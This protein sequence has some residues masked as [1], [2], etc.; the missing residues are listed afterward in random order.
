MKGYYFSFDSLL[1]LSVIAGSLF[2]VTQTADRSSSSFE[3]NT[4]GFQQSSIAGRD[5]MELASRQ[6]FKYFNESFQNELVSNTVMEEEDLDRTI[7]DGIGLLWA[8]QN[9]TYAETAAK[10]YFDSR[11]PGNFGYSIRVNESGNGSV[12]YNS[13]YI[14]NRTESVTAI[15]RLVSGHR[16]GRPSEGF[17]A[18]ARLSEY[19]QQETKTVTLGGYVGD[20]NINANVSL[21]NYDRVLN[22]SIEGDISGEFDLEVNGASAGSYNRSKGNITPSFYQVCT[23]EVNSSRC[24]AF[25]EGYNTVSF[26][27]P[28][29]NKSI[30]GAALRIR[31][32]RTKEL[33][34]FEPGNVQQRKNLPGID[35]IINYYG[36][37]HVPGEIDEI[38]S[39]LRY[40]V[41]NQTV[42]LRIA[43]S[44]VYEER[45]DGEKTVSIDNETVHENLTADGLDYEDI[46][47]RTVPLRFGLKNIDRIY[48]RAI[49]DSVAVID[50]SGSMGNDGKLD[51]AKDSAKTFVDIILNA[52]GNRAGVVGYDSS[53]TDTRYLTRDQEALNDTIDGLVADGGTCIACG[54]LEATDQL[55]DPYRVS[56]VENGSDLI[57]NDSLGSE[58]PAKDGY[59]WT[60]L[61]YN[62]SA[63]SEGSAVLGSEIE[64][65]TLIDSSG[66]LFFRKEFFYEP[67]LHSDVQVA[68]RTDDA[69]EVWLN[70][71][72]VF[73]ESSAEPP[74]YWN[75]VSGAL[76][77]DEY[78]LRF[79]DSFER[80]NLGPN[81]TL[82]QGSVG[83]DLELSD[84]CGS[85][86]GSKSMVLTGG[87]PTVRTNFSRNS[88]DDLRIRYYLKKGEGGFFNPCDTPE[89]GEDVFFE[90]RN[91]SGGWEQLRKHVG[92]SSGIEPGNWKKF[93]ILI[94]A[95][96]YH[97]NLK[98]RFRYENSQPNYDYWAVDRFKVSFRNTSTVSE[99]N[100]SWLNDGLN[101]VS[102]KLRNDD[103]ESEFDVEVNATQ[104]RRNSMIV[105]SDGEATEESSMN[106]V[107]DHDGDGDVD[108]ADH[109]I[110]AGCRAGEENITLYTVGFGSD[111]NDETLNDTAKCGNGTYYKSDTGEL[112]QVFRNISNRVLN[113]SF[114]GQR[115]ETNEEEALGRLYDDSFLEFN[116]TGTGTTSFGEITVQQKA[117]NFGDSVESPLNGSFRFPDGTE[118]VS[119]RLNSYSGN[120]WTDRVLTNSSGTWEYAYRLWRYDSEY[121]AMGDPFVV[122]I[123]DSYLKSGRNDISFDTA[124]SRS[125]PEGGSP[126]NEIVYEFN[127]ENFVGYG[128]LFPN[129]TAA[130]EDA[131]ERLKQKLDLDGDG[132]PVVS[133][134]SSGYNFSST[135]ADNQ[136]YIWGPAKV[137]LVI[138]R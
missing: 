56:L 31:Y 77:V 10:S 16:I 122:E 88:S 72:K 93:D 112:E 25:E 28:T 52:S 79:E 81:W 47:G 29:V 106:G 108:A 86:D 54:I 131:E 49:A 26:S 34:E 22:F 55:E 82:T 44:T 120:R 121:T 23:D 13:S 68:V 117:S 109:S 35:G 42:F 80:S 14:P 20:G 27:F 119:A 100:Q 19:T 66:P 50:D 92:G 98:V 12:I 39:R 60:E 135:F 21:P 89:S 37:F 67:D 126:D 97:E 123:P 32:N 137:R 90:Y 7:L 30:A 136:P 58:P 94:D 110:E 15:N 87:G 130:R 40:E 1:A 11:I 134:G 132:D 85:R 48:S 9:F 113:A 61:P 57:Y 46:S 75:T 78:I 33:K 103:S 69:A 41:D 36:A 6:S 127:V 99:V 62:D 124:L 102:A 3:A 111:V 114:V 115:I 38:E 128:G 63:W 18:R 118:P 8:A 133:P 91:A 76:N 74:E 17:Q 107:P 129:Q 65:E 105:L 116:Y 53:V 24:E 125:S 71:R 5:A 101:V 70:G 96:D 138:W 64:D 43:N 84:A 59:N 104:K 4:V 45:V 2:L 73:N 51:E 95:G 83:E